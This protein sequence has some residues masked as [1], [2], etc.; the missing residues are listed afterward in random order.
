MQ[1]LE[2]DAAIQ[3]MAAS[4]QQAD[5]VDSASQHTGHGLF[6]TNRTSQAGLWASEEEHWQKN[7][8]YSVVKMYLLLVLNRYK[9]AA[10]GH[11]CLDQKVRATKRHRSS[12]ETGQART[13]CEL[14]LVYH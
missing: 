12:L 8:L 9:P 3:E 4:Q 2:L 5:Q 6:D 14:L 11:R 7:D 1:P 13:P 10:V